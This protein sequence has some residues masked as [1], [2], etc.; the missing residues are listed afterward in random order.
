MRKRFP[1]FIALAVANGNNNN[2]Q[3]VGLADDYKVYLAAW[4]CSQTGVWSI[5]DINLLD[6]A[7]GAYIQIVMDTGAD[8][9]LWLTGLTKEHKAYLIAWQDKDGIW[10]PAKIPNGDGALR[11]DIDFLYIQMNIGADGNLQ[12]LGVAND[13]EVYFVA[14]QD[15]SGNWYPPTNPNKGSLRPGWKFTS[16][17][18]SLG[19]DGSLQVVGLRNSDEEDDREAYLV[20]VQHSSGSWYK[21]E[22]PNNNGRLR[23]GIKFQQ[24]ALGKGGDGTLQILGLTAGDTKDPW[25][26]QDPNANNVLLVSYQQGP[27]WHSPDAANAGNLRPGYKFRTMAAGSGRDGQLRCIGLSSDRQVY[28]V[29][30]HSNRGWLPASGV[31]TGI[32]GGYFEAGYLAITTGYRKSNDL[33]IA[34]L[35]NNSDLGLPAIAA[36][37][38]TFGNWQP[39]QSL[40]QRDHVGSWNIRLKDV[41]GAF[42]AISKDGTFEQY[43]VDNL[44]YIDSDATLYKHIQGMARYRSFDIF[45][46]SDITSGSTKGWLLIG[47]KDREIVNRIYTPSG[48]NHPSGCQVIGD[49]LAIGLEQVEEDSDK[50]GH[51]GIVRFYWL[52]CMTDTEEPSLLPLTIPQKDHKGA[53]AV[54]ITDVGRGSDKSYVMG[55]YDDGA[56]TISKSNGY[57]LDDPLCRFTE[58]FNQRLPIHGADNICLVTDEADHVYLISLTSSGGPTLSADDWADLYSVDLVNNKLNLISPP[59]HKYTHGGLVPGLFGIHFRWGAGILIV[60]PATLQ[61][62]CSERNV[63]FHLDINNFYS[64]NEVLHSDNEGSD[65]MPGS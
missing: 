20:V 58:V 53:G 24:L 11:P 15:K 21:P 2:L 61:L 34:G 48:Y 6:F 54:G 31:D 64:K 10:S 16:I 38:D 60:D 25:N 4:Q 28:L 32:L 30:S 5:P 19:G 44:S 33:L 52:G 47:N 36:K 51:D 59:C 40:S 26:P 8:G 49:Y 17:E 63:G 42:D 1:S 12:V 45:T 57:L 22:F 27:N 3:V 55:V 9:N 62:Y 39:G 46:H 41:P 14:G 29:A 18:M 13:F 37:M 50:P 35:G 65:F 56:V 7:Q 23:P 43:T